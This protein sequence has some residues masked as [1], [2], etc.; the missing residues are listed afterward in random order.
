[1]HVSTL[2]LVLGLL[3]IISGCQQKQKPSVL[4][5]TAVKNTGEQ[6]QIRTTDTATINLW[7]NVA[8]KIDQEYPDSAASLYLKT[9]RASKEINY[10]IGAAKAYYALPFL[11]KY[12]GKFEEANIWQEEA[13]FFM[14]QSIAHAQIPED[15]KTIRLLYSYMT[16]LYSRWNDFDQTIATYHSAQ[17]FSDTNDSLQ[18]LQWLQISTDA[19]S[20]YLQTGRYDSASQVYFLVLDQ[21]S[22]IDKSNYYI[23]SSTYSGI[24]Y[25]KARMNASGLDETLSWFKKAEHLGR[26]FADTN[27]ILNSIS[28]ITSACY[29]NGQY[30]AA[31]E[32]G[33]MALELVAN[34]TQDYN[35]QNLLTTHQTIGHTL[36]ATLINEDSAAAALPYSQMSLNAA[37]ELHSGEA[38]IDALYVMGYNLVALGRYHEAEKVLIE[39]I[40]KAKQLKKW[41]N[42]GNAY[43][44]LS[45]AYYNLGQYKSAYLYRS[46]YATIR[47]SLIGKENAAKVAEISA[48]YHIAQKDKELAQKDKALLENQLRISSQE[49]KLYIWIGVSLIGMLILLGFL[50]QKRQKAAMN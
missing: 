48:Q 28:N 11:Y 20:A 22:G 13:V 27:L 40:E 2:A 16:L 5:E 3:G 9:I 47:D 30:D 15:G 46:E 10:T 21:F 39:G 1:M 35:R 34:F 33:K 17:P 23:L 50:Y 7:M 32:H 6:T 26:Q 4:K 25:V 37:K 36:A 44:Q 49:K 29:D 12:Q 24:G 42:I 19:G 43:G 31:K 8:G 41:D 14:K 38:E 18:L 45:V